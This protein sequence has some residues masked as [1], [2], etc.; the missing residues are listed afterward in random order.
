[1]SMC[2]I[3]VIGIAWNAYICHLQGNRA[4]LRWIYS[5]CI[6][7][8][9]GELT[10]LHFGVSVHRKTSGCHPICYDFF[11]LFDNSDN[12]DLSLIFVF[13]IRFAELQLLHAL[14]GMHRK[15]QANCSQSPKS[16]VEQ[17]NEA[18]KRSFWQ[19]MC[20]FFFI[21][22]FGRFFSYVRTRPYYL[23]LPF[24]RFFFFHFYV[25]VH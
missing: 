10:S 18:K 25:R 23:C 2:K 5:F 14:A 12:C 17:S 7:W 8:Q 3:Q 21:P 4:C 19:T 6:F 24:K 15:M 16:R 11:S 1:M 20:S 22:K 13:F 9:F